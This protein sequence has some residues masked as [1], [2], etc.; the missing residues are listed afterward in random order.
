[1][2]LSI[3]VIVTPSNRESGLGSMTDIAA[4][5]V[6][7]NENAQRDNHQLNTRQVRFGKC[8]RGVRGAIIQRAQ[9]GNH[10]SAESEIFIGSPVN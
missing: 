5:Y 8:G 7:A 3:I 10:K 1:M 2:T 6:P 9:G 4:I